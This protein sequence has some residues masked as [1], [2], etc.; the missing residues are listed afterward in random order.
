LGH[1]PKQKLERKQIRGRKIERMMRTGATGS[2][3][4]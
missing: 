3:I 2:K 1:D 4:E